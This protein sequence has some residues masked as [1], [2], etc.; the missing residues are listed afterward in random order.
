MY[1]I[2][3]ST[4]VQDKDGEAEA[5]PSG[6]TQEEEVQIKEPLNFKG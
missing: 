1:G 2:P 3:T 5:G 4:K 6:I